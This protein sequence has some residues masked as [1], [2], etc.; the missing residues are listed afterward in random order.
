MTPSS[1]GM[2]CT[3]SS[4]ACW[5]TC[6]AEVGVLN[7]LT[8]NVAASCPAAF[9]KRVDP[10]TLTCDV[11]ELKAIDWEEETGQCRCQNSC[12]CTVDDLYVYDVTKNK[13]EEGYK[14]RQATTYLLTKLGLTPSHDRARSPT[15]IYQKRD[16]NRPGRIR[17]L[18]YG[19][20]DA[21]T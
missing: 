4:A 1:Y 19:E 21:W 10:E 15:T 18:P 5:T 20:S 11:G 6:S 8:E 17:F 3:A 14:T 16:F 7:A 2:G 13:G 9:M 12:E